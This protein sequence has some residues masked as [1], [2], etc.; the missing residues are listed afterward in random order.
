M[1]RAHEE[2]GAA[3]ILII[4]VI[5]LLAV[6][7]M[8][9]ATLTVNAMQTTSRDRQ[10]IKTFD[11]AEGVLDDAMAQLSSE[12]PSSEAFAPVFV[13]DNFKSRFFAG[14]VGSQYADL[15]VQ[16]WFYDDQN[17]NPAEDQII[18]SQDY[19]W[20][21]NE[22]DRMYIE[23]LARR[24]DQATRLRAL[25]QR[26]SIPPG[27][28]E[29]V[30]FYTAS[31]LWTHGGSQA[32]GVDPSVTLPEGFVVKGYAGGTTSDAYRNSGSVVFAANVS[33]YVAGPAPADLSE[34]PLNVVYSQPVPSLDQVVN[35]AVLTS[36]K[37]M[38]GPNN[39][40]S[41]DYATRLSTSG[42]R[43]SNPAD[44]ESI[45][46]MPPDTSRDDLSGP[47]FI[48]TTGEVGLSISDQFNSPKHPGILV[49]KAD[50]LKLTGN[51]DYYGLIIVEGYFIDLGTVTVHGAVI[52]TG[53]IKDS[54]L[55]GD[56]TILYNDTAW[57]YLQDSV[58][59]AVRVVPNSWRELPA[60]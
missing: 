22:N 2:S 38:A 53:G 44:P 26:D 5:A 29:G 50:G 32:I 58:S 17:E 34:S 47:V 28:P 49:V 35:P 19:N 54:E 6:L 37:Q 43:P 52:C 12:W 23:V 40:Y 48:E 13:Q 55:G 27:V 4:A 14:G 11:V 18:N 60:Q 3:L 33:V 42:F 9:L 1:R 30:A 59:V 41:T 7:A 16:A 56:Q 51:G 10:Q 31:K 24:G 36:M 46:P 15:Q 8:T 39:Y 45:S 25:V 21:K 20:D 57:Q